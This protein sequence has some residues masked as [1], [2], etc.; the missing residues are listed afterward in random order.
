MNRFD[1]QD[2]YSVLLRRIMENGVEVD[3]AEWQSQDIRDRP[4]MIS[5]ELTHQTLTFMVPY[6]E[7][8]LQTWWKPNMPWAEDHFQERVS[9]KPLNPPPS[10]A[11]WPFAVEGNAAHKEGHQFSH[12]YPER[13]WP[14]HAVAEAVEL[15]K[16]ECGRPIYAGHPYFPNHGIRYKLGD[17]N[18]VINMLT[19]NV[20]TRQAYL[21]IWFPED[22]G[23]VKGQRVPCTLGYHFLASRGS[24]DI[25]YYMRSCDLLRHFTDDAY[26]AARLLQHVVGKLQGNGIE[27]T[28]G[29]LVMHISSL[30]IFRGDYLK[31]NHMID[32]LEEETDY[33][34]PV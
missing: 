14:K 13:I 18:D 33:G 9:G 34:A 19:K 26:M 20:L 16:C 31:V 7:F 3:R 2:T 30:H 8:Q 22:T 24:L 6:D 10:E 32:G 5:R 21:P 28:A 1:F 17:L 15:F 4:E 11:W 25:V 29:K 27:V 23:A 12:T